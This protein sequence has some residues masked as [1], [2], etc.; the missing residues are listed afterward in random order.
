MV[1]ANW[2]HTSSVSYVA[3]DPEAFQRAYSIVNLGLGVRDEDRKWEVTAFV[4]NLFNQQYFPS[5]ANSA[6]NWGNNQATQVLLPRDFMRYG[7]VR[8]SL[9]Y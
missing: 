7:G 1:Q 4:N 5:L 9:N 3:R 2:Q 8:F 6:G